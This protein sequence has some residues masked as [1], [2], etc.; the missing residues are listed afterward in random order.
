MTTKKEL[1]GKALEA[2]DSLGAL[3]NVMPLEIAIDA[4]C[5]VLANIT[6]NKTDIEDI[7]KKLQL[8]WSVMKEE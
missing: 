4:L 8:F 3:V 7:N 1:M 2:A 5:L 6:I